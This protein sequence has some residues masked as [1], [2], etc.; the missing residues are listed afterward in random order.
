[1]RVLS[2]KRSPYYRLMADGNSR[3]WV[4]S[5]ERGSVCTASVYFRRV[6][7]LSRDLGVTPTGIA[8]MPVKEA[9]TFIHDLITSLEGYGNVGSTFCCC[10]C[11]SLRAA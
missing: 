6:G 9:R 5:L 3:R 4:E 8:A 10:G 1:M 7:Y 2:L 11:P